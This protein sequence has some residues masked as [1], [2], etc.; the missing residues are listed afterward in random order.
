MSAAA[1]IASSSATPATTSLAASVN[2]A[3]KLV[4]IPDAWSL[5]HRAPAYA[6]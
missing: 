5:A 3:P 4:V 1:A 6:D 2:K